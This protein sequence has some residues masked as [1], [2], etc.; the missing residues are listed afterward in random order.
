MYNT[1]M[2]TVYFEPLGAATVNTCST[3]T[4]RCFQRNVVVGNFEKMTDF[5]AGT[6]AKLGTF[7]DENRI[8][9]SAVTFET[10]AAVALTLGNTTADAADV[11]RS[12]RCTGGDGRFTESNAHLALEKAR[13]EIFVDAAGYSGGEYTLWWLRF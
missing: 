5:A 6:I 12:I 2:C 3:C 4:K 8:R 9:V 13:E 1:F 11:L 10:E 7:V